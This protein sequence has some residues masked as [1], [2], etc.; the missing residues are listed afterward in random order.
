MT[1][2]GF[3]AEDP[4]LWAELKEK[5]ADAVIMGMGH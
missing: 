5:K 3:T 4:V 2:G 1:G